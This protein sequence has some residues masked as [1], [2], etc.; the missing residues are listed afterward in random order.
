MD[1]LNLFILIKGLIVYNK[2][3]EVKEYLRGIRYVKDKRQ[4]LST[5][6]ILQ[7]ATYP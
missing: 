1:L 2:D 6:G 7:V 4:K 3:R 5:S